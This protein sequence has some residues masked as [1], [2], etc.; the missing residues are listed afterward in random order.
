MKAGFALQLPEASGKQQAADS[1][2]HVE[3]WQV[4]DATAAF[5]EQCKKSHTDEDDPRDNNDDPRDSDDD[6]GDDGDDHD[7]DDEDDDDD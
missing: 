7:D 2:L 3:V 1:G 4:S 6:N 5:G